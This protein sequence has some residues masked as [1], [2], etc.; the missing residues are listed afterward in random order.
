MK[1]VH[2]LSTKY[3]DD[4]WL[5]RLRGVA[6][7]LVVSQYTTDNPDDVPPDVW[8]Q[9]EIL[10]AWKALPPP[11]IAPNLRWIQLDTAGYDHVLASPYGKPESTVAVT[12]LAGVAP[13]NMAEHAL[14]MMLAFAHRLPLLTR[15]QQA[16]VWGGD[17]ERRADF[18]PAELL[19]ATVGVVGYGAI[20]REVGRIAHSFGMKVLAVAPS[21][22][23]LQVKPLTY[24]IPELV[25]L[26]GKEPDAFYTPDRLHEMLALCDYVVLVVPHTPQTHHML[27]AAA[28]AALKPGAVLVNIARG[29]VVDESAMIAALRSGRL[30]GAALDVFEQEPLPTESPLWTMDNVILS[31]HIAGLTSRYFQVV[32]DIFRTN[33]RRYLAGEPLLNQV[34]PVRKAASE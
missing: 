33:L 30:A 34:L 15:R 17:M 9:V 26:P 32:F 6:P 24:Q 16:G 13:P 18:T 10:Y 3:F 23:S 7:G 22:S 11:T 2:I 20:G 8:A 25:G 21:L 5:E 14:L 27:D 12:N 31:P 1:P 4:A 29:G 28:F 19:G